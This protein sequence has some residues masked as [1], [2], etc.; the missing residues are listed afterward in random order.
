MRS[1]PDHGQAVILEQIRPYL[2][3]HNIVMSSLGPKLSAVALYRIQR[4]HPQIG[5]AY[6]PSREF[7]KDYSSGIS[8]AITG[9]LWDG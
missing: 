4:E 3:S 2:D 8:D 7:N 6:A 9:I 1:V 5:L